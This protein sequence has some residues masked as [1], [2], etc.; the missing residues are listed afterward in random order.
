[1]PTTD[2]EAEASK[3]MNLNMISAIRIQ[4]RRIKQAPRRQKTAEEKR[5]RKEKRKEEREKK[6]VEERGSE[7]D[8]LEDATPKE[9]LFESSDKAQF[10]M[11]AA[12]VASPR[13]FLASHLSFWSSAALAT[14]SLQQPRSA[15]RSRRRLLR[16]AR[17]MSPHR[18]QPTPARLLKALRIAT[19]SRKSLTSM[20]SSSTTM[21][22]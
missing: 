17:Q 6:K 11:T 4:Y 22:T 9:M 21:L 7:P 16:R 18:H 3:D 14:S 15:R 20:S 13:V 19:M 12:Y 5:K 2:E 10:A 8:A 1:M